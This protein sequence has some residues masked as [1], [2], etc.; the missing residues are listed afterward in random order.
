M[1][2]VD[3]NIGGKSGENNWSPQ[4]IALESWIPGKNSAGEGQ[5]PNLSERSGEKEGPQRFGRFLLCQLTGPSEGTYTAT[6]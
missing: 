2:Y 6:I 4:Q 1:T 5:H 3:T